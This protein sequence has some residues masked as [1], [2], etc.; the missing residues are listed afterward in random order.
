MLALN[1]AIEAARAGEHGRG[2]AVVADE[3]RTL[4]SRTQTST[5]EIQQV[6]QEL[7]SNSKQAVDAMDR[8]INTAAKGVQSTSLAGEALKRIMDKVSAISEVSIQIANATEEQHST[9][10]LIEQYV[11][12]ME[13]SA[14]KVKGTTAEMGGISV[15][16]QNVT[17]K[18]QSITDQFK[19]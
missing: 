6:L 5:Q 3:V 19:V 18:L 15:D 14:Q 11:T 8:S 2:F 16:I 12:D 10:S 9:S 17:E 1:A 13:T 7:R 4:A